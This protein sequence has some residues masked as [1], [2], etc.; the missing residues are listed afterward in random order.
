[1]MKGYTLEQIEAARAQLCQN[2]PKV[3]SLRPTLGQ[4]GDTGFFFVVETFIFIALLLR[5]CPRS[6]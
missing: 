2:A 6:N 1:M 3:S 5:G 4:V